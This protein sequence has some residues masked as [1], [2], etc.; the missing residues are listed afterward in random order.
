VS[1]TVGTKALQ[2]RPRQPMSMLE[3]NEHRHEG[4]TTK[5]SPNHVS[6]TVGTKALQQR[7]RQPMSMLELDEHRHEG[8]TSKTFPNHVSTTVGTK[9]YNKSLA[10]ATYVSTH[11]R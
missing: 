6:T 10:T 8:S 11:E 4:S 2:Q 7:P 9:A 1:T 5:T 3:P